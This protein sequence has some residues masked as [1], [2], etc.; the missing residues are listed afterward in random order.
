MIN[1]PELAERLQKDGLIAKSFTDCTRSEILQIVEAVFSSVGE[2]VPPDGWQPPRLDG[3]TLVIP[4]DSHP[5]YHWWKSGGKSVYEI[6]VELDAPFEV[7][8]KYVAKGPANPMTE[9]DWLNR[10]IPF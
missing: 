5:D 9:A 1:L 10:L 4:H 3:G 7:A 8:R 6:L 2:D